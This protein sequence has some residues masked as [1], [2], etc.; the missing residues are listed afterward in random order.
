MRFYSRERYLELCRKGFCPRCIKRKVAK[1]RVL[2]NK[3]R[4]YLKAYHV[5]KKKAKHGLAY[6]C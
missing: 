5:N 3:C 1:Q 2:C 6:R 4:D